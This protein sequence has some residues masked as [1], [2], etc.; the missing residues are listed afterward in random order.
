[1]D[2]KILIAAGTAEGHEL[3]SRLSA[4]GYD[5]YACVATELGAEM[6]GE[7]SRVFIGRLDEDGFSDLLSAQKFSLVID[8]THPY[9]V[10]VSEKLRSACEKPGVSYLRV[11]RHASVQPNCRIFASVAEAAQYLDTTK[12][13]ILSA[14]GSKELHELC[15]IK[16]YFS[17][18]YPRLLP[19]AEAVENAIKLGFDKAKLLCMQGPFSA[20]LNEALL[21]QYDCRYLL[22]KDGGTPGGFEEKLLAAE[23]C[24]AQVVC[25][26]RPTDEIGLSLDEAYE[27]VRARFSPQSTSAY[28]S[29]LCAA[30]SR[31]PNKIN[32][33]IHVLGVGPGDPKLLSDNAVDLIRNAEYVLG[34]PRLAKQLNSINPKIIGMS[35]SS[36]ISALKEPPAS[37]PLVL[38]SGDVGLFSIAETLRRQLPD[39][40]ITYHAG[41]S[42]LSYFCAKLGVSYDD[43]HIVSL[44]GKTDSVVAH[45]CY[46]KKVFFLTGGEIK[47]HDVLRELTECGLGQVRAAVGENLSSPDERIEQ[48][49]AEELANH[50]YTD[51]CCVYVE[52]Q[53]YVPAHSV[54]T[55]ADFSRSRVPI[56]KQEIRE[57]VLSK[58]SIS[59]TDT[60]YDVGAG[61]GSVAIAMARRAFLGAVHAIEHNAAACELIGENIQKLKAYNTILHVGEASEVIPALPSPDKVF[62]GGSGGELEDIISA[63]REKNPR[64]PIV[65][66]AVTLE[67]LEQARAVFSKIGYEQDI[68]LINAAR[69]ESVGTHSMMRAQSPIYI[70]SGK[71]NE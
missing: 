25:I 42:S 53:N 39:K 60:V 49:S 7:P 2:D 10:L 20:E 22:T 35:I 14:I 23:R 26:S 67:T 55:D 51:L 27:Y 46:H 66:T 15:G 45:V 11:A 52:N 33:E 12:G 41:L 1:M 59:P 68:V 28:T 58:L 29:P 18:V 9:A 4:E 65:I 64:A 24:G 47:A 34:A 69:V 3:F 36:I 30:Y 50:K 31:E 32:E 40:K 63:V 21:R 56:T 17:R 19:A 38:A 6:L 54:L 57:I 61:S 62:I 43:M 8:A 70:I 71:P 44:H 16:N 48:G 37:S 5:V 13:G